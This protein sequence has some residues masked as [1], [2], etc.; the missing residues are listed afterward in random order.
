[1]TE[2]TSGKSDGDVFY[3][4][5]ASPM[6]HFASAAGEIERGARKNLSSP[7]QAAAS[8]N[9][10]AQVFARHDLPRTD[11]IAEIVAEHCRQPPTSEQM[12]AWRRAAGRTLQNHFGKRA[13]NA[14]ADARKLVASDEKLRTYLESSGLGN[15]PTMALALAEAGAAARKAGR[16]K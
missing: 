8:A 1:M 14:L 5:T 13:A 12:E 16:L 10:W 6:D 15:H 4:K 11:R 3:D 7:E 2:S 9:E